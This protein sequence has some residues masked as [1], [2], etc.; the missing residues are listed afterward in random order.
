MKCGTT[1]G[2]VKQKKKAVPLQ[3]EH[4]CSYMM[5]VVNRTTS[6]SLKALYAKPLKLAHDSID[7]EHLKSIYM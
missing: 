3:K 5:L 4:K 1:E 7:F 2:H 6:A